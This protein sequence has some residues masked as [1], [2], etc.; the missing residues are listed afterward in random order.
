MITYEEKVIKELEQWKATFMKDSSMM[1]RFSKKVQTK[2]QQL[3]PAK[4]QKVLTETI[5][6]MVQTISAGA[7]FIKPK[8]KEPNW[9]LQRRDD[10]V[11]KKMDEYKKIAA[12]EGAG[13]GAGGILL[14]LADFPLLLGIKIKFL[15]D[16]ATLYGFDTSDKEE[17][18][19]ILHVFQLAFS[20]DE[21]R[22]E[23]WKAIETWDTEEENHM[24][25]EKFQTE[26]RD[27]IDLAKML[28]LVP[29]IG[30]PVGAYANYQLLQRLG[31]V[32]MNCY[33]MRLLNRN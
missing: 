33:R 10:E 21:H 1:T 22:K 27:Y 9:S 20:S 7:N 2:V 31:E 5:R 25:W 26:Y 32:T 18:L 13:T 12:A 4:V 17:R 16:A 14:G 23:I 8:L 28:Q 24:D 15:F 3:I 6:M 30:A 29:I 11:R 19:F